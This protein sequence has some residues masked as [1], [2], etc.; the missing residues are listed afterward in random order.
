VGRDTTGANFGNDIYL[1]DSDAV[2]GTDSGGNT[3]GQGLKTHLLFQNAELSY[4]INRASNFTLRLGVTHRTST[5]DI[6]DERNLMVYFG[7]RTDIRNL[8]T[9]F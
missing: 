9:D 4:T 5:S 6:G 8:Y 2:R 1:S 7:V 3:I